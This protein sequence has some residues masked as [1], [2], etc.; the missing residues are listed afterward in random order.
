MGRGTEGLR[1]EAEEEPLSH[2][3]TVKDSHPPPHPCW[4]RPIGRS[5]GPVSSGSPTWPLSL[6]PARLYARPVDR[7]AGERVGPPIRVTGSL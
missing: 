4:G 2:P 5:G 7:G 6:R 3:T 1:L